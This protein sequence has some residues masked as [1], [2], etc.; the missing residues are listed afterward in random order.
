MRACKASPLRDP[1]RERRMRQPDH[2]P[3]VRLTEPPRQ[4]SGAGL[5]AYHRAQKPERPRS[6]RVDGCQRVLSPRTVPTPVGR[7]RQ[8]TPRQSDGLHRSALSQRV[9]GPGAMTLLHR[10]DLMARPE[11]VNRVGLALVSQSNVRTTRELHQVLIPRERTNILM[12]VHFGVSKPHQLAAIGATTT[13][14][15]FSAAHQW[16]GDRGSD[17]GVSV[18]SDWDH[19]RPCRARADQA[20]TRGRQGTGDCR[21]GHRLSPGRGYG[22]DHRRRRCPGCA[23]RSVGV[24]HEPLVLTPGRAN[25]VTQ[26]AGRR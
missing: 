8:P 12:G 21:A 25:E 14:L 16:N 6:L 9:R 15:R 5:S 10:I 1:R 17:P 23:R 13:D 3:R 22:R 4:E 2:R 26:R 18:L 7:N 20:D 19:P 24:V 11:R